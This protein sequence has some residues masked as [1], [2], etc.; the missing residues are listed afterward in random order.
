MGEERALCAARGCR[1]RRPAHTDG[2]GTRRR[3]HGRGRTAARLARDGQR[4]QLHG[5]GAAHHRRPRRTCAVRAAALPRMPLGCRRHGHGQRRRQELSGADGLPP[6][7]RR[8]ARRHRR[9]GPLPPVC[10]PP[11]RRLRHGRHGPRARGTRRRRHRGVPHQ[12]RPGGVA[13]RR[14]AARAHRPAHGTLRRSGGPHRTGARTPGRH[15]CAGRGRAAR[16]HAPRDGGDDLQ[17]GVPPAGLQPPPR[18]TRAPAATGRGVPPRRH[19]PGAGNEAHH[20]PRRLRR[21]GYAGALH[22]RERLLPPPHGHGPAHGPLAHAPAA[23]AGVPAPP[24]L[25]PA[26]RR[27]G[28]GG[29]PGEGPLRDGLAH[30]VAPCAQRHQQRRHRR[31]HQGVAAGHRP[32]GGLPPHRG[33]RPRGR[34]ARRAAALG[35]P[36]PHRRAGGPRA[37]AVGGLDGGLQG[38]DAL[39]GQAVALGLRCP[40]RRAGDADDGGGAGHP[41]V[42][43]HAHAAAAGAAA[44][45]HRPHRLHQQEGR[46][47]RHRPLPAHQPRRVRPGVEGAD[48]LP[49]APRAAHGH[50]GAH[51]L[52]HRHR[53][54][55]APRR[56]LRHHQLAHAAQGRERRPPLPRGGADGRHRHRHRR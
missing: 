10:L 54:A 37:C 16:L 11:C 38:V 33:L 56:L 46:A 31:G 25:L 35:R 5:P 12:P 13:Q 23:A 28:R 26:Q 30:A 17:H 51:A 47:A 50:Q 8:P 34:V 14:R 44:V 6:D 22:L 55:A 42:H 18:G 43:L 1:A 53:P 2:G 52:Y 19:R 4:R 15:R 40:A 32:R 27:H 29:V 41:Q 24:L 48:G 9:D 36:R 21:T 45:L 20:L 49:Q 3:Q 7:W 39:H